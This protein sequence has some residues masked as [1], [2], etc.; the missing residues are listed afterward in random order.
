M[1]PEELSSTEIL[2]MVKDADYQKKVEAPE[3]RDAVVLA[4]RLRL[5][6]VISNII[7]NSYKY[8]GTKIRLGSSYEGD[9]P[10]F[11]VMEISD[12]GGGVP[13]EELELITGKFKRGSNAGGKDGSGLGLY[14][15][16]YFMERMG[17]SLECF[18]RDGGF[19]VR[20][21]VPVA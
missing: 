20:L 18:N 15:S 13:E 8:A 19:T 21:K 2:Q 10:Q 16:R 1:K 11:L 14:I 4:D 17:G 7:A 12:T 6:Q 3:L 9:N 5:N